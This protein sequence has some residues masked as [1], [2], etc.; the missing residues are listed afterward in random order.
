MILISFFWRYDKT[1]LQIVAEEEMLAGS[2]LRPTNPIRGKLWS[3]PDDFNNELGDK[4]DQH[5]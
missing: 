2:S 4:N 1:H 3:H 5:D